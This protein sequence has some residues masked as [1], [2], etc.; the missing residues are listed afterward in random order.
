MSRSTNGSTTKRELIFGGMFLA[1]FAIVMV[2]GLNWASIKPIF[3]DEPT[4]SDL[5]STSADASRNRAANAAAEAQSAAEQTTTYTPPTSAAPPSSSA[6][7]FSSIDAAFVQ[8]LTDYGIDYSSAAQAVSTAETTCRSIDN[9]SSP[10]SAI[11]AAS[12]IAQRTGGYSRSEAN[13]FVGLAVIAYCPE[14]NSY[15]RN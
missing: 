10:T 3:D 8:T 11:M 7:S 2:V 15:V 12:E 13:D 1:I 5:A 14:Y 9:A 6:G 4:A